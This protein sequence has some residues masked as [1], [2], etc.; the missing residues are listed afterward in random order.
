M[1]N[2][3]N[4]DKKNFIQNQFKFCTKEARCDQ[5]RIN[6]IYVGLEE[7]TFKLPA[8]FIKYSELILS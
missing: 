5:G 7:E 1:N 4:N 6:V 8:T 3:Y 2:N